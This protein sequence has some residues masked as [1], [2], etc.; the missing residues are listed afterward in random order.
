M[1]NSRN[2]N[3]TSYFAPKNAPSNKSK[4][5]DPANENKNNTSTTSTPNPA[6]E[7]QKEAHQQ[8]KT[9]GKRRLSSTNP[10][11]EKRQDTKSTKPCTLSTPLST[12]LSHTS[13]PKTWLLPASPTRPNLNLTYH[14]GPIFTA[15]P[16]TLL[17]HACNTHG[18]WGSGIALAFKQQYPLAYK[19][20]NS[21]CLVTH[22]PKTRPVPTGT[23]LLIPPVDGDKGHWIGCLFTS[24]GFGKAKDGGGV[25]VGNTGPAMEMLLEMVRVVGERVDGEEGGVKEVRMCRI[26][27]GKFG[28]PWEKSAGVLEG[29]RVRKGWVGSV[30][31]WDPET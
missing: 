20:Y 4:A 11:S 2:A 24:R 26:N 1:S 10:T 30:Q 8:E 18:A 3:I 23:A 6:D 27:S 29:I 15:P 12:P 22:S 13:L 28:V 25:I 31:V 5:N 7:P 21:F 9:K 16:S 17:I 14:T 19:I